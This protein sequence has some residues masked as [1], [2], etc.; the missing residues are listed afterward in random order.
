MCVEKLQATGYSCRDIREPA[1]LGSPLFLSL[2][3]FWLHLLSSEELK[4]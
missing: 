1:P 3:T 2:E 4:R